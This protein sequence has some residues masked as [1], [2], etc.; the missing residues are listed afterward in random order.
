[1][2]PTII[3]YRVV[4]GLALAAAL[5]YLCR[6]AVGVA[7]S[8]IR[9]D[10]GLSLQQSGWFMGAFF[11]TYA[12]FQVPAGWFSQV[13]GTRFA[14]TIFAVAW[15]VATLALGLAPG[16]WLLIVAQFVMGTAQAGIFPASTN[17]IK[18]WTPLARRS[19]SCALLAAGMQVGAIVA[20]R[21][22]GKLLGDEILPWRWIF[23]AYSIP[24]L[25]WSVWFALRFRN[26]PTEHPEVNAAEVALIKETNETTPKPSDAANPES[27]PWR[28][29]AK[30]VA[31]RWLC[32]QQICRAAGY[33]FF[34]SWFP[35]FLQETRGVSV[36]ASGGLQAMVF[37][38]TFAGSL[39]GGWLT[40]LIW[41]RTG[42]L[43]LSRRLVGTSCL[44]ACGALI[45][46]AW[47]VKS[48]PMAMALLTSGAFCAALAGP[49]SFATTIDI[50]GNHVPQVMGTMNMAGNLSAAATPVLVGHL[51][52]VTANWN[53]VL[54]VFA[55]IYFVGSLC[56]SRVDPGDKI[57][58]QLDSA[59]HG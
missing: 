14:L 44:F 9:E 18:H 55:V 3:R 45:L 46:G 58:T 33:M 20:A 37:T 22:T 16:F 2:T 59:N 26:D 43:R 53:V 57:V 40:D 54:V 42:S 6:N 25:V 36:A 11:W 7:E 17:S 19:I 8:T 47:F 39:G 4:G 50:G 15:S 35:T 56:W 23:V 5:A 31:L 10:L 38:A 52:S 34:A 13:R 12:L 48:L 30:N 27:T 51:F 29:M 28:G 49:C 41:S 32:G 24:G 1:M 21:L